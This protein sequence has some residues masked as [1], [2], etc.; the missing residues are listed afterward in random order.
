[1]G[2]INGGKQKNILGGELSREDINYIEEM[3]AGRVS[4]IRLLLF[5]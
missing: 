1:M 2:N 3:L 4:R 5:F